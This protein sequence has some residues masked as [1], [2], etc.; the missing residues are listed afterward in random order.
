MPVVRCGLGEAEAVHLLKAA[1][2]YIGRVSKMELIT[3]RGQAG[4]PGA[5]GRWEEGR[6]GR[7]CIDV[8]CKVDQNQAV[9]RQ[10]RPGLRASKSESPVMV[11]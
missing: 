1:W 3:W 9:D 6:G 5:G 4:R 11:Y 10:I 2:I 7:G 8:T